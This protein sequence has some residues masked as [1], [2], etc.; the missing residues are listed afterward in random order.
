MVEVVAHDCARLVDL[1]QADVVLRV[2]ARVPDDEL[3]ERTLTAVAYARLM[4]GDWP[5]ALPLF[6][7]AAGDGSLAPGLA[8]RMGVSYYL[9]GELDAAAAI[10]DRG[11]L[12]GDEPADEAILLSWIASAHWGQGAYDEAA[13]VAQRA[14]VAARDCGD[15]RAVAAT[16]TVLTMVAAARGDRCGMDSHHRAAAE[17]A[18]LAGDICAQ[19]RVHTNRADHLTEQGRAHEAVG[20][21]EAVLAMGDRYRYVVYRAI[22]LN[23]QGE[24]YVCLGR[25]DAAVDSYLGAREAFQAMGS[26][27]VMYPLTG[28]GQIHRARGEAARARSAFT[29]AVQQAER[30]GNRQGMVSAL[31]GLAR[32]RA[33]DDLDEAACLA[34]RAAELGP[35][36]RHVEA[37]LAQGWIA[38]QRGAAEEAMEHAVTAA[39]VARL[40]RD[41]A[42]LAEALEL[43]ACSGS[44]TRGAELA[45][46]AELWT[47]LGNSLGA[48]RA[49][50][51]AARLS[52]DRGAAAVATTRLRE[53]GVRLPWTGIADGL[54]TIPTGQGVRIQALG[55]FRVLRD[56]AAV[57]PTA[58]QSKKARDL[59]KI[60]V[61][62][63]GRP[64]TREELIELLWPDDDSVNASN[65]LSVLL[66]TLR[67]VLDPA[68]LVTDR[69]TVRLDLEH[70]ETDVERFAL[71]ATEALDA[72]RQ[73]RP[74]GV[75][76][77]ARAEASYTG[78]FCEEDVYESWAVHLREELRAMH[79]AVVRALAAASR[80]D[81][82]V[83]WAV[84]WLLAVLR[85]DPYDESAHLELV[86]T[87]DA[88][89]RYGDARRHYRAY[90]DRM[91]EIAIDPAPFPV[92]A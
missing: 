78:D 28:L 76:R 73:R 75:A 83:D 72:W 36:P 65:R 81:G 29:E 42:G 7:R 17:A 34:H 77:L 14:E 69:S 56:G 84:R 4:Y 85:H 92:P 27:N 11:R 6:E 51:L 20:E 38:L 23:N 43:S 2:A 31:A 45:D 44:R 1:G 86:R 49:Q 70:V 40:R 41:E 53:V 50:L 68:A 24:A 63:R 66:S 79:L 74:D 5:A 71:R 64:A 55:L 80:Q 3:D 48:A 57:P 91:T 18:R 22:A 47:G 13:G 62:R 16:Q 54:A 12:C 30:V 9:R 88:A 33:A 25:Y 19:L 61:S 26:R 67:S 21:L 10:F 89:G 8:W 82:H 39:D 59:L 90:A 52:G 35:G 87:L 58:W 46:A 32:V 60:L 37:R 15:I